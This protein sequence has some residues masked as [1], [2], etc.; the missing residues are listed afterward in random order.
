MRLVHDYKLLGVS[1]NSVKLALNVLLEVPRVVVCDK[2]DIA[3]NRFKVKRPR[4]GKKIQTYPS[5][6]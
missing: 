3:F 6:I 2:F 5:G 1:G 4:L